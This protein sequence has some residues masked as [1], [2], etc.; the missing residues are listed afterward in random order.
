MIN[1]SPYSHGGSPRKSHEY[2]AIFFLALSIFLGVSLASY[3]PQDPSINTV[4]SSAKIF[5]LTG[6]VGS[7]VSDFL[8]QIF[9]L[10]SY[11]FS[12]LSCAIGIY[13]LF[14]HIFVSKKIA[15]IIGSF[16]LVIT[17]ASFLSLAIGKFSFRGVSLYA[18]GIV[19]EYCTVTLKTY[20]NFFGASIL[21]IAAFIATFSLA[22]GCRVSQMV[23]FI[24]HPT[25]KLKNLIMKIYYFIQVRTRRT[26]IVTATTVSTASWL[27]EKKK[28]F[29]FPHI[30]LPKLRLLSMPKIPKIS[31]S[32]LKRKPAG[33]PTFTPKPIRLA[34]IN[35]PELPTKELSVKE[36]P[37]NIPQTVSEVMTHVPKEKKGMFYLS[38]FKKKER[39]SGLPELPPKNLPP[40]KPINFK[41]FELPDI[42][43][44]N[45]NP[46]KD[47]KVQKPILLKNSQ[48]LEQKLRD[49]GVEGR[50]TQVRPGPVITLYEFA[51]ASGIKVSKIANLSD[52]LA[53]SLSALSVRI[54]APIPGK[55]VVGIEIPNEG[56]QM[57]YLR[58]LLENQ[59]YKSPKYH[60][61]IPLGK[62]ALGEPYIADLL[63]MPHLLI[64]G[65]TGAGKSV[66]VN[67]VICSFLYRF[68]PNNLRFIMIDPKMLELS[69]YDDIPNLLLPV[70]TDPRKAAMAL[71]WAVRE[72]E[73]RY[74]MMAKVGARNI[75]AFN[76]RIQ[77]S[78]LRIQLEEKYPDA[79]TLPY[80]IIIIDELADL[81]MVTPKDVEI[82][83]ARLA[84][85]A[86]AA[87]IHLILA[88]QRPSVDVITGLIKANFPARISFQVSS[89]I[90]SRTIL[91]TSGAERLLG[92]GDMLYLAPGTAK[93]KR[94]HGAY[95]S[96]E[97]IK[98]ICDFLRA[99]SG[100]DYNE[101]IL[102]WQEEE[103]DPEMGEEDDLYK[104]AIAIVRGSRVASISMVQRRLR[105]GYNRAARMIERMEADGIVGPADGAKPREVLVE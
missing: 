35:L 56:R 43:L 76:Q 11:I 38:P 9:G 4:S 36:I 81:M 66:F 71:K 96:D 33:L 51:P 34:P 2:L 42:S 62:T 89:K 15:K 7:Y 21:I 49:F 73:R 98:A 95:I 41:N 68:D 45:V 93:L 8:L 100:P 97:E 103:K 78:S 85:M 80:I 25:L 5:N 19:G 75:D 31:F 53:L 3:N 6:I 48:L 86:R 104:E 1:S 105:I 91:D 29:R 23:Y 24:R 101:T 99:Q 18:G 58:E 87:G 77:I 67:T 65:A 54:I 79:T 69:Y 72:M 50:V 16:L 17:C 60:I 27:P 30:S 55:N 64:A 83:I 37:K 57:V 88:T 26:Q 94:I 13:L 84:Q 40:R 32:F 82:S 46:E 74:D 10:S 39:I 20:F 44:L 92:D 28:F 70:V 63:R 59:A 90:D 22:T 14:T 12:I 52:D 47:I 102:R 61:P